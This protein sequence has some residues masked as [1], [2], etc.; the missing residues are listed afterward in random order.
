ME[1]DP[2]IV[3]VLGLTSNQTARTRELGMAMLA[4]L[5]KHEKA[6]AREIAHTESS[7]AYE[8][9]PIDADALRREYLADLEA[10]AGP[11]VAGLL[12]RAVD[13]WLEQQMVA[14]GRA[15][16]T[17]RVTEL[18]A[19]RP[20]ALALPATSVNVPLATLTTPLAVLP[21]VGVNTAV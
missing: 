16:S 5:K 14:V 8:L 13:K 4:R 9:P 10:V 19:S 3:T 7:I 2:A 17:A 1:L 6:W 11:E 12:S 21:G 20:S 15:V 18:L